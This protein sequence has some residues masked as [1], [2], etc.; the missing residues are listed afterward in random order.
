MRNQSQG[1]NGKRLLKTCFT[2]AI[3][4]SVVISTYGQLADEEA[5]VDALRYGPF[6]VL[7]SMRASA[8]YDDNIFIRRDK[9][10]DLIWTATPGIMLGSGDYR[11]R[12]EN[13]LTVQYTPTFFL[14]TENSSQ[15]AIDHEALFH[16]QLRSGP[17]RV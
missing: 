12:E 4:N 9:E 15:N 10:A 2:A 11:V 7:Y 1:R 3:L 5:A 17:M 8:T 6:D 13:L 16:G 14:F